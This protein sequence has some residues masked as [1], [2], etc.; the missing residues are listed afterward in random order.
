MSTPC[1]FFICGFFVLRGMFRRVV[2]GGNAGL[3]A[4]QRTGASRGLRAVGATRIPNPVDR[5][6]DAA[7]AIAQPARPQPPAVRRHPDVGDEEKLA[8]IFAD[9]SLPNSARETA[10]GNY[11]SDETFQEKREHLTYHV[12]TDE[13]F[14]NFLDFLHRVFP[15]R[16]PYP[17]WRTLQERKDACRKF[18]IYRVVWADRPENMDTWESAILERLM[19]TDT[20][21]TATS[22]L[23]KPLMKQ[24]QNAVPILAGESGAGKTHHL[25]TCDVDAVT[26]YV[27]SLPGALKSVETVAEEL[28]EAE[29]LKWVEGV[30]RFVTAAVLKGRVPPSVW[31]LHLILAFDEMGRQTTAVRMLCRCRDALRRRVKELCNAQ[32][33]RLIAGGT[34]V[35]MHSRPGS[36]PDSYELMILKP[37]PSVWQAYVDSHART[38]ALREALDVIS[39]ALPG[40]VCNARAAVI[41]KRRI[42]DLIK[43]LPVEAEVAQLL[44]QH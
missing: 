35:E 42:E 43:A 37:D 17:K 30:A 40:L 18:G 34:G 20:Y 5:D 29:D 14:K 19:H 44:L 9:A 22:N 32:S 1:Y 39:E 12:R 3:R 11:L 38:P 8:K 28:K 27:L 13:V 24:D 33:V 31:D 6:R 25:L 7:A 16:A 26:V 41:L 2:L 15:Y 23:L 4:A 10:V 21:P 36:M